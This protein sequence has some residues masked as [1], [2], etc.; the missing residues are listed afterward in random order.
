MEPR[1]YL[2][3]ASATPPSKPA[4]PSAGY[5]QAAV[6]GVNEATTPGP[7]WFYKIGE[8]LRGVLTAA[9][10]T[11][12]DDDITQLLT[13]MQTMFPRADF[14]TTHKLT[15]DATTGVAMLEEL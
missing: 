12:S 14:A 2:A 15:R 5:P 10:L 4:S 8:E 9:G 13:A 11:P 1:N 3:N 6:P 7:F